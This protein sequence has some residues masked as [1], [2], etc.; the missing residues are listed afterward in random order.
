MM[1]VIGKSRSQPG[2]R[3]LV[4][5]SPVTLFLAIGIVFGVLLSFVTPPFQVPDEYIHYYRSAAILQGTLLP[6]T[7][8]RLPAAMVDFSLEVSPDPLPGNDQ[9]KQSKRALLAEFRRN[10]RESGFKQVDT[11]S[12]VS[13]SPFPYLT[14]AIGIGLGMLLKLPPIAGFYLGR[15]S[16]LALWLLTG[17][18]VLK[19]LPCLKWFFCLL[20]LMPMVVFMTASVSHDVLLYCS[21]FLFVTLV[22]R[23][24]S[25]DTQ[26]VTRADL[27]L[28]GVCLILIGL[29]KPVFLSLAALVLLLPAGKFRNKRQYFLTGAGLLLIAILP[30]LGWF[31]ITS[32]QSYLHPGAD[33]VAQAELVK[34]D[35]FTYLVIILRSMILDIPSRA[36][37]AVGVLG[38]AD[39]P[40]PAWI[41]PIYLAALLAVAILDG[42]KK[43]RLDSLQRVNPILVYLLTVFVI[44]VHSYLTRTP[45]AASSVDGVQGR[46]L[47]PVL[48]LVAISLING[49]YSLPRWIGLAIMIFCAVIAAVTV[50]TLIL[51]YYVS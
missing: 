50:R 38:W 42:S 33:P 13:Y 24:A 30:A 31:W 48:P 14:A 10:P 20:M 44:Y 40:L 45:V 34:T 46:Y 12:T 29:V 35:P 1:S 25:D 23:L 5:L 43:I 36:R 8:V 6:G 47:L 17:Y 11:S 15:L 16:N 19:T 32:G 41:T 49:K 26:T 7:T 21:S 3:S 28:M 37:M 39:T 4:S 2:K 18:Y 22:L 51:R 9:N 27:V